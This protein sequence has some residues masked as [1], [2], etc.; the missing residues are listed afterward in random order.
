MNL[1]HLKKAREVLIRCRDFLNGEFDNH[2]H[3][4]QAIADVNAILTWMT[5]ETGCQ[6]SGTHHLQD[7]LVFIKNGVETG[8]EAYYFELSLWKSPEEC[9]AIEHAMAKIYVPYNKGRH[10]V[11][12]ARWAGTTPSRLDSHFDKEDRMFLASIGIR[13][14]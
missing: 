9:I 8:V 1:V 4:I 3:V 6:A 14:D 11:P 12:L 5:A 13:V 2:S 10:W 7:D